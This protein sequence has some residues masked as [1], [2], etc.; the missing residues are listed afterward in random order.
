MFQDEAVFRR[1][2]K[3]KYC[4]C[5][6]GVRP[7]VPCYHIREFRYTYGAVE[8]VAGEAFFLIMPYCNTDCME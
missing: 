6:K 8:P 3:P 7:H 2:N 5:I 4:W 1:V